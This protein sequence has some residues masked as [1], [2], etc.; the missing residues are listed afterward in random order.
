MKAL[1]RQKD[2]SFIE[3]NDGSSL[4]NL[5]VVASTELIEEYGKK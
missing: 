4:H 5:Q 2:V 3:I 1:R